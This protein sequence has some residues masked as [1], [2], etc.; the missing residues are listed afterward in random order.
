MCGQ[1]AENLK[2]GFGK[3]RNREIKRQIVNYIM[4]VVVSLERLGAIETIMG[5]RRGHFR[6]NESHSREHM[7]ARLLSDSNWVERTWDVQSKNNQRAACQ[8]VTKFR[9]T[10]PWI[11][12]WV[13]AN[14]KPH[15]S[16]APL[17]PP[18]S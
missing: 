1:G 4:S 12:D 14:P 5:R 11:F 3:R 2:T 7:V 9:L 16:T 18:A 10:N 15:G 17:A 6:L 13:W 8:C